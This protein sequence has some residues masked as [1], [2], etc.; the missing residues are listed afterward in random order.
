MFKHATLSAWQREHDGSYK[1]E[2]E[3]WT[4]ETKWHP[5]GTAKR[6]GFSWTAEQEGKP[7]L[8]GGQDEPIEEVENAMVAAEEAAK[9]EN[10]AHPSEASG[11]SGDPAPAA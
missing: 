11:S 10:R 2:I 1:A 4:L 8:A 7:K 3:G 9:H 6:R 5:E